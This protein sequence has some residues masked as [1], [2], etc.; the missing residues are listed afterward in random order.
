MIVIVVFF[1]AVLKT[2]VN[3]EMPL[4]C[5][6]SVSQQLSFSVSWHELLSDLQHA[7]AISADDSTDGSQH[8]QS[9]E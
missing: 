5:T 9:R 2:G 3:S 7:S 8:E 6:F 4:I 1:K